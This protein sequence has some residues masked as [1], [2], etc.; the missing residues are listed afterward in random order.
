MNSLKVRTYVVLMM[1]FIS[2]KSEEKNYS[3]NYQHNG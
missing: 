2:I 3:Y 1:N